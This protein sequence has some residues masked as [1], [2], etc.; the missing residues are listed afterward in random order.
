MG[1]PK[2]VAYPP[3]L[4]QSQRQGA[5]GGLYGQ[6][7]EFLNQG[8]NYIDQGAGRFIQPS[9]DYAFD[10][11]RPFS[12]QI[13]PFTDASLRQSRRSFEQYLPYQE[14]LF[15]KQGA[16]FTPDLGKARG[17]LISRQGEQ[18][19]D[20]LTKLMFGLTQQGVG[21]G[22]NILSQNLQ[23]AQLGLQESQLGGTWLDRLLQQQ[24]TVERGNVDLENAKRALDLQKSQGA[25]KFFSSFY[26]PMG[27][28]YGDSMFGVEGYSGYNPPTSGGNTDWDSI[29]DFFSGNMA[30]DAGSIE[31]GRQLGM[32]TQ[33]SEKN[34]MQYLPLIL[35][36]M[37]MGA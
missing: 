19:Q 5:I 24:Y 15:Q 27:M 7:L 20:F 10:I 36:F 26:D 14:Q 17:E 6:G 23:G 2:Y 9:F 37:S 25:Q 1:K 11:M 22:E 4:D 16:F 13:G 12:E 3:V 30:E 8:A 28:G 35:K 33:G 18:E 32:D 34:M 29:E 31:V 21:L